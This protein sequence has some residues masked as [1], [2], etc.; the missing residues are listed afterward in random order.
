MTYIVSFSCNARCVMC[1]SWKKPPEDELSLD[2]IDRIFRQLPRL[3]AVRLTGGEPT[4][5]RDLMEIHDLAVK[6]LSPYAVH[7]TSNGFLTDRL[8]R[9]CEDRDRSVPLHLMISLD[10]YE[11]THDEIRGHRSA[12]R[13]ALQTLAE[14]A[15]RQRE[16]KVR[17]AVNQTIV[18]PE[19]IRDYPRL[20]AMLTEL[21]VRHHAVMAYDASATYSLTKNL[22]IAPSHVGEFVSRGAFDTGELVRFLDTLEEDL[23][24]LPW[25]ER[26][27]KRYYLRGIRER[28]IEGQTITANPPCVALSSHLRLYPNGDVP[29]CQFNSTVVGNLR[30]QSFREVWTSVR[31]ETQRDWVHRC[32]GC[33][34]ECEVLPN[35]VYSGD[36]LQLG[37]RHSAAT[38]NS[39]AG[40][41][42]D[43]ASESSTGEITA[44]ST[45]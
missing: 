39:S 30:R 28:I 22:D 9:L 14:V 21:G 45:S 38:A 26:L 4:V 24:D 23:S 13:R 2:E 5:R 35:A 42:S 11:E 3:D 10:G 25:P 1:D 40:A 20:H 37:R 32:P 36:L 12:W 33:W 44:S 18:G 31:A 15:P 41:E 27:A 16:L 43:I 34:A 19:G 8:V 17:L 29:T 7:I 6:R